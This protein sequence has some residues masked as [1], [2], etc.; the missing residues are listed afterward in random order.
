[1]RRI[2]QRRDRTK[3]C[4]TDSGGAKQHPA[5]NIRRSQESQTGSFP[6]APTIEPAAVAM[7]P[8]QHHVILSRERYEKRNRTND[9]RP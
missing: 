4:N 3:Q 2:A 1:V 6:K 9:Y 7:A 8:P 5:A